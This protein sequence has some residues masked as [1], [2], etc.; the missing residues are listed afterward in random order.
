MTAAV[1]HPTLRLV[2]TSI[3]FLTN[4]GLNPGMHR[5]MTLEEIEKLRVVAPLVLKAVFPICHEN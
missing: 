1:G 3:T 2:R 4:R 5:E